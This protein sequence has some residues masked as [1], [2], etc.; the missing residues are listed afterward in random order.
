MAHDG[1]SQ[2]SDTSTLALNDDESVRRAEERIERY[3]GNDP[4]EPSSEKVEGGKAALNEVEARDDER[5]PANCV[6]WDGPDDPANPQNWS[7]TRKWCVTM[8]CL[9]MTV[10]V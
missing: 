1:K 3:G 7:L 4:H 8:I 9:V 6:T 5:D 10:N 2:V